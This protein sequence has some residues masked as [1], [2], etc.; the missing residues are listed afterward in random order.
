MEHKM[1]S[2]IESLKS[3]TLSDL[4][5]YAKALRAKIKEKNGSESPETEVKDLIEELEL[6]K[7]IISDKEIEEAKQTMVRNQVAEVLRKIKP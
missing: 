3:M 2:S 1:P 4:K 5:K 7:S 6:V